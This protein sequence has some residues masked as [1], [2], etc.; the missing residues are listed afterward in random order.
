[1]V[2]GPMSPSILVIED[3][4]YAVIDFSRDPEIPIPFGEARGEMGKSPP[5]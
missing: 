1:V 3:Y 5:L 2:E 4:P